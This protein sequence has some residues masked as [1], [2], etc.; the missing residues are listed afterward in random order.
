MAVKNEAKVLSGVSL[1][2]SGITIAM[3]PGM[4][5]MVHDNFLLAVASPV[6]GGAIATYGG[7]I[8]GEVRNER[9]SRRQIQR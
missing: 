6:I 7:F 3:Q 5:N 4:F 8:L 2:M 9:K 1:I